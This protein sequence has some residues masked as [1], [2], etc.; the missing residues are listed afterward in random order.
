MPTN[1]LAGTYLIDMIIAKKQ[2]TEAGTEGRQER[3]REVQVNPPVLFFLSPLF[4]F[5]LRGWVGRG[6]HW[7]VGTCR[8]PARIYTKSVR[9]HRPPAAAGNGG[10][11]MISRRTARQQ[12]QIAQ[13]HRIYSYLS[14]G[15]AALPFTCRSCRPLSLCICHFPLLPLRY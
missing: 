5:L 2:Y 11:D 6:S 4:F 1:Q 3:A 7:L 14:A 9:N 13:A 15:S 12:G 8:Q 10:T